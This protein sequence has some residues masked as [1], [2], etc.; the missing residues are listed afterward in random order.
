MRKW[1]QPFTYLNP[2]AQFARLARGVLV[3]GRGRGGVRR[4]APGARVHR[5][6]A[7]W[8]WRV[9]VQGAVEPVAEGESV[10]AVESGV[11]RIGH[12]RWPTRMLDSICLVIMGKIANIERQIEA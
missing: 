7:R 6:A 11:S 10:V 8:L 9:A 5:H 4:A 12:I 1:I 3:R 2:I